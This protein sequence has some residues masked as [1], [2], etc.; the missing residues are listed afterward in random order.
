MGEVRNEMKPTISGVPKRKKWF[1]NKDNP[2][3]TAET[4]ADHVLICGNTITSLIN[5]KTDDVQ[6]EGQSEKPIN[7]LKLN[8]L[9]TMQYNIESTRELMDQYANL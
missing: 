7:E 4:F 6:N 3:L 2:E 1:R 5:L 9:N 8:L